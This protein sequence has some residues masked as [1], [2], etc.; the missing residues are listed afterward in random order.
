VSGVVAAAF[1]IA[2]GDVSAF[3]PA[4][5]APPPLAGA[6]RPGFAGLP[7]SGSRRPQ[8]PPQA[9]ALELFF[10][11][12]SRDEKEANDALAALAQS[13]RDD[14]AA[15]VVDIARLMRP[16]ARPSQTPDDPEPVIDD[17]VGGAV[18]RVPDPSTPPSLGP[19]SPQARIRARLTR[20]L[21]QK[22]G[23]RFGDDLWTWREWIWSRP[24]EPHPGYFAFKGALY[25]QI[26]PRMTE[27]FKPGTRSL[28]RLDEVD[29]G[30]V[31][32]N[33]IPPLGHPEMIPA[34]Q[35]RYLGG[36]DIVFGLVVN[37]EARA[38]PKRILAWHELARDR[39]GGVEMTIVYCTLCGTVIPYESEVGGVL[40]TF[41][42]SGLLY[43]SNKL[44]FDRETMS[45]WSTLEGRP[46]I[47]EL[48]GSDLQLR[49]HPV[50]TTT[51]EEWR[52]L[53]PDTAVLSL[54]TGV[55]RDYSEG[56]AYRDYFS[57]DSLMFHVSKTDRRL[58]N[59]AEVLVMRP[60]G[61]DG[62]TQPV[63]IAAEF[64]KKNPVHLFES[65]G[66]RFVVL[67]TPK[68]ANRVYEAGAV[69]FAKWNGRNTVNDDSGRTWLATE[70]ALTLSDDPAWSSFKRLP[71]Q[72]A[73][74]FAW[75]AQFPETAL[76]R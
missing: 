61:D 60:R 31:T 17:E 38:Y 24:Y 41:G 51:W 63:A 54:E 25:G 19:S 42:T 35:A 44:M 11:A 4:R 10:Q 46:V 37:G 40:R 67:T 16:A 6:R 20:F 27:F 64:L 65:G 13:W 9:P 68:G 18:G 66:R 15:M 56:A 26:D 3:F 12:A 7:S 76:T 28:V 1:V 55:K 21:Q 47:G 50:V 52:A 57:T 70:E 23:K 49:A 29:W 39:I 5:G 22:T 53:H 74:W 32:V 72:R 71:A 36:G 2:L 48:A 45:L 14:Y 8:A 34:A 43:R 59:K 58:K 30:G 62:V 75:Y 73:F 33:G 69:R